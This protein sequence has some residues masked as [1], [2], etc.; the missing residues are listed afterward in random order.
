[1]IILLMDNTTSFQLYSLQALH[2]AAKEAGITCVNECGVDPGIHWLTI[3]SLTIY[4]LPD[5][6]NISKC[7][8][9]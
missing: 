1:M 4:S 9:E 8:F 3:T 2:G 7:W 6:L 5:T